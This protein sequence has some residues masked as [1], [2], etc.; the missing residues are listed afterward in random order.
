M[1]EFCNFSENSGRRFST[2]FAENYS[3]KV[4]FSGFTMTG[5]VASEGFEG[6][7]STC[8]NVKNR[9]LTGYPAIRDLFEGPDVPSARNRWR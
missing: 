7:D 2:G 3:L 5:K 6:K 1:V 4:R 9:A 8:L